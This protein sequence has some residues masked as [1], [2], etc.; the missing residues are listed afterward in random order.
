M[1]V[2]FMVGLVT[3]LLLSPFLYLAVDRVLDQ[4]TRRADGYAGRR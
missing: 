2:D 4:L 1:N 3:G